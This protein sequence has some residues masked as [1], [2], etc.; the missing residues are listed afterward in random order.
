MITAS[1]GDEP[2]A[3]AAALLAKAGF[4]GNPGAAPGLMAVEY[5]SPLRLGMAVIDSTAP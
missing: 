1:A 2:G 4:F 5:T 3:G